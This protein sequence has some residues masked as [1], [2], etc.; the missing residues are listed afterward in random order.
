MSR[1]AKPMG[2]RLFRPSDDDN[3][4]CSLFVRISKQTLTALAEAAEKRGVTMAV[5][6]AELLEDAIGLADARPLEG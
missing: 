6:A 4:S 2:Q 1:D 3:S 5:V